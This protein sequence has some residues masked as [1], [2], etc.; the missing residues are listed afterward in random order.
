MID[1][2]IA[3]PEKG[4]SREAVLEAMKAFGKNDPDYKKGKTWSLVYYLGEEYSRFLNE[5]GQMYASSNGLN[6]MAFQSLKRF[7]TE[8]VRMTADLLNGD[9]EVVGIMTSGGT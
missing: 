7:E 6:P 3:L 8:V 5:A 1:Q 9:D 2:K 4:Q